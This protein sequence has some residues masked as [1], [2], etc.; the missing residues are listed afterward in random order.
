MK[1]HYS[2]LDK[3]LKGRERGEN[4]GTGAKLDLRCNMGMGK[5]LIAACRSDI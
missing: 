2:E 1:N 5:F 3:I 4:K